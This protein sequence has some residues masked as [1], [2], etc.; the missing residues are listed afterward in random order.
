MQ[1]LDCQILTETPDSGIVIPM[2]SHVVFMMILLVGSALACSAAGNLPL[3]GPTP[4]PTSTYTPTPTATPT[5]TPTPL[6]TPTPI[7]AARI[8]LGEN[9]I[10][11]GNWDQA[12]QEFEIAR[13]ASADPELQAAALL[14]LGRTYYFDAEYEQAVTVLTS[15][16]QQYPDGVHAA[17]AYFILG[18][19]YSALDQPA[20]AA[21]AYL[22]YVV[23]R[24]GL[25]DGYIFDLRAD[26]L[27]AAADY[28]GA[29]NDYRAAL[30]SPSISDGIYIEMKLAR[31]MSLSGDHTGAI[32]LYADVY[33]RTNNENSKSLSLLRRGQAYMALGQTDQAYESWL[34]VVNLHPRT[35]EAYQALVE[36]VNAGQTVD[37]LQ[38]GIVDY[39]AGQYGVALAAIDRYLQGTPLDPGTAHYFNGL[40]HRALGGHA[41]AVSEF[42]LV[43]R[44]YPENLYWAEALNQ[45][46]Y[47]EWAFLEQYTQAIQTLLDFVNLYAN[48]SRAAEF[49]FDAAQI[50]NTAGRLE[51]AAEL[52]QQ[53]AVSYPNAEQTNRAM[54]LAG[55][56][57]F[58]LGDTNQALSSFQNYL[59]LATQMGDR[60]AAYLWI[61]KCLSAQGDQAGAQSN[62]EMAANTDP[63][64]YY[65]ERARDL[66]MN[67]PAFTPPQVYDLVFDPAAERVQAETWLRNQ[68]GIPETIDLSGLGELAGNPGMIRANELWALGMY[69]EARNEFEAVRQAFAQDALQTYRLMNYFYELGLYRS[70]IF[71]ARQVLNLANMSDADTMTAPI[72]F[73]HIRFG[74]YFSDLIIPTAQEYELHPLLIF[75]LVRQESLFEGFIQSSAAASG[76]MQIIPSTGEEIAARLNWPEEYKQQDLYRPYINI[77]FGV[78]YLDR[79]RSYFKGDLYTALAAYNGGPGNA[80]RWGSLAPEDQD[81]FLEII[82]FEETRS[83]IQRIYEI[84]TIYRRLYDRTP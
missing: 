31:A 63:T 6:P 83:Y 38:R 59:G 71:A 51:Q 73:N 68:F 27:F 77:Q 35:N 48:H 15:I 40:I 12:F 45:K 66:L 49:L 34:A 53:L 67:R 21:Q 52:Y 44:D 8:E 41:T 25:V 7:P 47:T 56:T 84:F 74:T 26:A 54:F 28:T 18:Q 39:Y 30:Q 75:S 61:G 81:L 17:Y 42:A 2:K 5:P 65:S 23:R 9:A 43:T 57:Y 76:L 29:A 50:A 16:T 69:N 13:L 4:T 78:E 55:I 46:A 22:D 3:F 82:N 79:Q 62:W 1:S 11:N 60:A 80:I 36:L 10:F 64:G 37:E 72:Y 70:A 19:I 32:A 24:S 33:A 14:G 20:E 58:R